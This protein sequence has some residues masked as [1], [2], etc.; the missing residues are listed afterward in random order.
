MS[1]EA[2]PSEADTN[3]A[4][5]IKRP[6]PP[7]NDQT[8]SLLIC[9]FII[10]TSPFFRRPHGI[11]IVLDLEPPNGDAAES[12]I[13]RPWL[14]LAAEASLD[15]ATAGAGADALP[16]DAI[17]PDSPAAGAEAAAAATL[18]SSTVTPATL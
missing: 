2:V 7:N 6:S 12:V 11:S 16:P 15:D 4:E 18:S 14:P 1:V 13:A 5:R 10:I 3:P 8:N 9:V 17:A